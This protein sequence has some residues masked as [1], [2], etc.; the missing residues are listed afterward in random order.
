MAKAPILTAP[1]RVMATAASHC[2]GI[3][4][5]GLTTVKLGQKSTFQAL[6]CNFI[7]DIAGFKPT[8]ALPPP[9]KVLIATPAET[10]AWRPQSAEI[11]ATGLPAG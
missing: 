10:T 4:N 1:G 7:P 6:F 8:G 2:P 11:P 5:R 9:S 3:K